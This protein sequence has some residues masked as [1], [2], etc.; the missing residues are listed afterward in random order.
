MSLKVKGP[1]SSRRSPSVTHTHV[2]SLKVSAGASG[3]GLDVAIL[4]T[5]TRVFGRDMWVEAGKFY[6]TPELGSCG[7]RPAGHRRR[8]CRSAVVTV[9]QSSSYFS[10]TKSTDEDG[11][12]RGRKGRGGP[13]SVRWYEPGWSPSGTGGSHRVLR[14][15]GT[16]SGVGVILVERDSKDTQK[17]STRRTEVEGSDGEYST[18]WDPS[19]GTERH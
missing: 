3:T 10:W 6:V 5:F 11:S 1:P 16:N 17:T 19:S 18:P 14:C 12:G 4:E 13:R 15:K 7:P 9:G 8:W 2:T